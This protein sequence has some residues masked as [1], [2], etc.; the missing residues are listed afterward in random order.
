MAN[1]ATTT[2][3][4]CTTGSTPPPTPASTAEMRQIAINALE[5]ALADLRS[6]QAD[7]TLAT[8]HAD[9]AACLV[10]VM[11]MQAAGGAQ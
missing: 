6:D 5:L 1:T 11:K 7:L 2:P 8:V 4:Q 10:W 9:S 3:T